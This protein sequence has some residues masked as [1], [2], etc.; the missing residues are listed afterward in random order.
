VIVLLQITL[1]LS[2]NL[3]FLNWLSIVPLWLVSMMVSVQ[4]TSEMALFENLEVAAE[5]PK[6]Q[7]LCE[8]QPGVATV[9]VAILSIQPVG[10]ILSPN[11]S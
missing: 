2:G 11:K 4:T 10:N 6:N 7:K 9:L 8:L 5:Q 1:I 3:S